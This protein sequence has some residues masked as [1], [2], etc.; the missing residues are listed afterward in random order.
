MGIDVVMMLKKIQKVAVQHCSYCR[1]KEVHMASWEHICNAAWHGDVQVVE[2]VDN[3]RRI[4]G[5]GW[6]GIRYRLAA[7][8]SMVRLLKLA[9][10]TDLV[11]RSEF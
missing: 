8:V 2:V 5:S 11:S 1:L 10:N 3:K 6:R 7:V 4:Q 9:M